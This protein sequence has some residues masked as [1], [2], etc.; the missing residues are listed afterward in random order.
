MRSKIGPEKVYK[1]RNSQLRKS[2]LL[3]AV[4]ILALLVTLLARVASSQEEGENS[5]SRYEEL[6]A[7]YLEKVGWS[8]DSAELDSGEDDLDSKLEAIKE[9]YEESKETT[10]E[11]SKEA[12]DWLKQDISK[13]G[14]W[15]YHIFSVTDMGDEEIQNTLATMGQ[16]R[17]NLVSAVANDGRI[18]FILKRQQKSYVNV[19]PAK[20]VLKLM[21][22]TG[23]GEGSNTN[24]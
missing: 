6:K 7:L 4:A 18:V 21:S 1:P 2:H 3:I 9:Y 10:A 15:D 13:I 5:S 16:E 12:Y 24:D 17:W 23:I 8:D 19:L 22:D 11:I 14:G 20:D